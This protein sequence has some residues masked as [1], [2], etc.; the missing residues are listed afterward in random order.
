MRMSDWS[1]DVCSSDLFVYVSESDLVSF[2]TTLHYAPRVSRSGA[3]TRPLQLSQRSSLDGDD[4]LETAAAPRPFGISGS[5]YEATNDYQNSAQSLLSEP[6][7]SSISGFAAAPTL[8]FET[9]SASVPTSVP[10]AAFASFS[11]S[12]PRSAEHTSELPSL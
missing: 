12:P 7:D 9:Q 1:S 6:A 5:S 10:A 2:A 8:D 3:N 4:V 11:S